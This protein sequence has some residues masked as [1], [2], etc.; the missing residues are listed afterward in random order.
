M[1]LL[2]WPTSDLARIAHHAEGAEEAEA[3]REFAPQAARR[4]AGVGAHREAAAQYARAL[5]FTHSV[6]PVER[7][8]LLEA[9]A[10]EC[11]IL[12]QN[13]EAITALQEAVTRWRVAGNALKEGEA[14]AAVAW[15]LV[16]SG[17]NAEAEGASRQAITLLQAQPPLA[18][19]GVRTASRRTCACWTA[20][21]RR[22]CA[23]PARPS[24]WPSASTTP[25][26]WPPRTS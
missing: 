7:A 13:G 22:R 17:R 19:S 15:P 21:A 26:R 11:A 6:P 25:R 4:A 5:R 9:Y 20:T 18:S 1:A 8:R 23:G 24:R 2:A 16:R 14:L 3:V 12:D 10:E